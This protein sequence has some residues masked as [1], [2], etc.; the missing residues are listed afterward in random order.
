MTKSG[1]RIPGDFIQLVW[2]W[3]QASVIFRSD[4]EQ[5]SDQEENLD[6]LGSL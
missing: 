5:V 2:G 3:T 6:S 1:P 4:T